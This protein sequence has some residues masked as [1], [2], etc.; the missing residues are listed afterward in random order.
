[1]GEC[2]V[3][4]WNQIPRA[5]SVWWPWGTVARRYGNLVIRPSING[6]IGVRAWM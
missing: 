6:E 3:K 2:A 1:M 4:I 5:T